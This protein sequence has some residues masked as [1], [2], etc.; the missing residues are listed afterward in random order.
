MGR[1]VL[2]LICMSGTVLAGEEELL[3]EVP[4]AGLSLAAT[5]NVPEGARSAAVLLPVAGPSDRDLSLGPKR[6]F[7]DL[8]EAFAARGIAT[9]RFDDRGVGG[10][11]GNWQET[12]FEDRGRDA[13][14]V[15]EALAKAVPG[16]KNHGYVGI[17]EGGGL[18]LYAHGEC[19]P[20]DYLVLLS[21]PM[22]PGRETLESQFET[23][24]SAMVQLEPEQVGSLRADVKRFLDLVQTE[25]AEA[26]LA[27][28]R[29]L[30]SGP[31]GSLLLPP[32][33]FVPR[34]IESRAKFARSPWYRSQVNYDVAPWLERN[35]V[36]LLAI[37]GELDRVLSVDLSVAR[38]KEIST[39]AEVVR[40]PGLNHLL[41]KAKTGSPA[42]YGLLE[43]TFSDQVLRQVADWILATSE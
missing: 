29:E 1:V 18:A 30:L 37:Y 22:L 9:L 42:E 36:P 13:C 38:L 3:I 8:A 41:Q 26:G 2:L 25:D 23:A 33:G 31:N 16:A 40:V 19:A 6:Y 4:D 35:R 27:G 14:R 21:T 15:M 7:A 34:D 12:S 20:A 32:Y 39:Q 10:S 43:G 5:L 17:S 24:L 28:M 11:G